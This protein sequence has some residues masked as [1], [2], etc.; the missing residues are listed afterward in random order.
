MSTNSINVRIYERSLSEGWGSLQKKKD[1]TQNLLSTYNFIT[2][3]LQTKMQ[4]DSS[5]IIRIQSIF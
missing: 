5:I 1:I 4:I 3:D 2:E